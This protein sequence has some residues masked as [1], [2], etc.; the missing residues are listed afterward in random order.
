[1]EPPPRVGDEPLGKALAKLVE[2]LGHPRP[3]RQHAGPRNVGDQASLQLH[4]RRVIEALLVHER[5]KQSRTPVVRGFRRRVLGI[6]H[7]LRMLPV[8]AGI[9]HVAEVLGGAFDPPQR[10]RDAEVRPLEAVVDL[11]RDGLRRTVQVKLGV[12]LPHD[13]GAGLFGPGM[14]QKGCCGGREPRRLLVDQNHGHLWNRA[15]LGE[16]LARVLQ[17]A[18]EILETFGA[19]RVGPGPRQCGPIEL[20]WIGEAREARIDRLAGKRREIRQETVRRKAGL[21][22]VGAVERGA[23]L[24]QPAGRS[25]KE[26]RGRKGSAP[27]D[28][29]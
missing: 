13:D 17:S 8:R 3:G 12:R 23:R 21:P 19:Q 18:K 28:P 16:G 9:G 5:L 26:Q 20:P 10:L 2:E 15:V 1:M 24:R 7:G 25:Q 27:G 22:E 14:A 4:E 11:V 29:G 6:L